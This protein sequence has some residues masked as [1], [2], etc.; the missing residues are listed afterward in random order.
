M[1]KHPPAP[2]PDETLPQTE[3]DPPPLPTSAWE[4]M[5]TAP[6]DG[7]IIQTKADPD[8]PDDK[9]A[10]ARWYVTRVRSSRRWTPAAWWV[11]PVTR[12]RLPFEPFC[13]RPTAMSVA[14]GMVA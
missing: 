4:T 13:W 3:P 2:A 1:A 10:L 9:A 11:D 12:A 6:T 5:E 7:T 8:E 14:P